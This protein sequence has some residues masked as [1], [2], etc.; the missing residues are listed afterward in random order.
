VSKLLNPWLPTFRISILVTVLATS[1]VT[2]TLVLNTR[3]NAVEVEQLAELRRSTEIA[4]CMARR[5]I[6]EKM[7]LLVDAAVEVP[8]SVAGFT[9]RQVEEQQAALAVYSLMREE[10]IDD[11]RERECGT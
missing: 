5:D 1:L 8:R 4:D 2:L 3:Q 7:L 11:L 6:K 9:L 10:L